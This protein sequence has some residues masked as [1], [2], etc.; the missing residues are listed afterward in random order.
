M[1]V[2]SDSS[3]LDES[4]SRII[5][6]WQAW[7]NGSI[8]L[9]LIVSGFLDLTL[10]ECQL[11]NL[12]VGGMLILNGW[13]M[14]SYRKWAAGFAAIMGIWVIVCALFPYF[15]RGAGCLWNDVICGLIISMVGFTSFRDDFDGQERSSERP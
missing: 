10:P 15:L 5:P 9:W 11:N 2:G 6:M 7:I 14:K 4:V 12:I 13:S 3:G 8:G 1:N